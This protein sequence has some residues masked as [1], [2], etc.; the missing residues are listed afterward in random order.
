MGERKIDKVDSWHF[1]VNRERNY[2]RMKSIIFTNFASFI[3]TIL[4]AIVLT[5]A[6]AQRTAPVLLLI[7]RLRPTWKLEVGNWL[8]EIQDWYCS[9]HIN[10][11]CP[12]KLN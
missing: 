6:E 9:R 1:M 8:L 7:K 11:G 5:M 3:N 12:S 10:V 4:S 2:I